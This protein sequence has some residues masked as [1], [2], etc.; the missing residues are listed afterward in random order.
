MASMIQFDLGEGFNNAKEQMA[1]VASFTVGDAA[2]DIANSYLK[3]TADAAKAE[4]EMIIQQIEATVQD[5][6][7]KGI[8]ELYNALGINEETINFARTVVKIANNGLSIIGSKVLQGMQL[9]NN[10]DT[11]SI[12]MSVL[13]AGMQMIGN[14]VDAYYQAFIQTYGVY[15]E[16]LVEFIVDPGSAIELL[17]DMMD[18]LIEKIYGMIDDLCYKYLG[19]TLTQIRYYVRKGWQL[20]KQ[21]K[22]ARKKKKESSEEGGEGIEASG[23]K[24]KTKLKVNLDADTLKK[25]LLDWMKNQRDS[26]YNGFMIMQVLD[27]V[28]SVRNSSNL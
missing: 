23:T 15:I 4:M 12:P 14:Y 6:A 16:L 9:L 13:A 24:K 10:F 3:K 5:V 11:M 17:K 18:V 27:A 1:K 28:N 7:E 26:L 21:Y 25:Q 2:G 8:S 19:I 22:E 20:Y